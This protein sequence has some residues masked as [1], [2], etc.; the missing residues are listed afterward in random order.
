MLPEPVGGGGGD[1]IAPGG[2]ICPGL[3][4][5]VAAGVDAAAL[6]PAAG[7][8]LAPSPGVG[9]L[10]CAAA[11]A[12]PLEPVVRVTSGGMRDGSILSAKHGD[13]RLTAP[14]RLSSN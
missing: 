7:V 4:V 13:L 9:P 11:A 12:A 14:I 8:V 6:V 3:G 5:A 10:E 1:G 2:N